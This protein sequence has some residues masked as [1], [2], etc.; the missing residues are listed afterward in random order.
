MIDEEYIA[1]RARLKKYKKNEYKYQYYLFNFVFFLSLYILIPQQKRYKN[2][3]RI[4]SETAKVGAK[5][6]ICCKPLF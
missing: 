3:Y 2:P 5:K 6:Y 4:V 1:H